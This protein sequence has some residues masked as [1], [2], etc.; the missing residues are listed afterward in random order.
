MAGSFDAGHDPG[1]ITELSIPAQV[2]RHAIV[3][4][5]RRRRLVALDLANGSQPTVPAAT[6]GWCQRPIF[7]R[8]R[9]GYRAGSGQTMHLYVG[10][11]SAF[12]CA[13]ATQKRTPAPRSA[14]AFVGSLGTRGAGLVIWTDALGVLARPVGR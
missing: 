4:R 13:A 5:D 14:P 11:H 12:P 3:V 9:V 2:G 10:A 6:R 8:Q 7:Y 1:L